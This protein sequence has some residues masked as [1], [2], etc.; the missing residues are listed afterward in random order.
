[1]MNRAVF[2]DRD[3]TLNKDGKSYIK[4][5]S[6][7]ELFYFVPTA[8]SILQKLGFKLIVISNQSAIARGLTTQAEVEKIHEHLESELLKHGIIINGIYYCSHHPDDNCN[9]RKPKIGNISKAINEHNINAQRSFFIGDSKRDIEAGSQAGLRTIL[10]Q[11]GIKSITSKE[12]KKW[13]VIPDYIEENLL[14]AAL[15]IKN[16]EGKNK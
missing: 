8:L 2:L 14:N 7:F 1:M 15:L 9:C 11:S 6:E 12:V 16:T 3:G 4:N 13:D 5:L 10:V